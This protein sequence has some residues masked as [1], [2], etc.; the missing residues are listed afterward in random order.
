MQKRE[1]PAKSNRAAN[2]YGSPK[3]VGFLLIPGFALMS[4]PRAGIRRQS[5]LGAPLIVGGTR[6]GATGGGL[7]RHRHHPRCRVIP[8]E[9]PIFSSRRRRTTFNKGHF[10][11]D[12]RAHVISAAFRWPYLPCGLLKH[13]ATLRWEHQP[14][15][16]DEIE[17]RVFI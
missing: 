5:H 6:L 13:R 12:W 4:P 9:T 14:A 11:C 3:T 8:S 2:K 7:E 10:V 16:A 17:V 1:K 15:L